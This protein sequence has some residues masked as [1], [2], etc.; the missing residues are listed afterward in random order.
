MEKM[1]CPLVG[2]I[3]LHWGSL[4]NTLECI[5]SVSNSGYKKT[6]IIL[7]DNYPEDRIDQSIL[8]D[9]NK[10]YYLEAPTN[11]GYCEGNNAGIKK[12]KKFGAEYILLLNNDTIID[13]V[14]IGLSVKY[15]KEN[16][17]VAVISPKIYFYK[18]PKIINIAGGE[19]DI[20]T[21]FQN[22]SKEKPFSRE[23]NYSQK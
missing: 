17:D 3:I 16:E 9:K 20:N 4:E 23:P 7:V 6:I 18:E 22:P 12:A 10:I 21:G 13:K 15:M 19:I 5:E 14:M 1:D 11:L 2:V 8:K